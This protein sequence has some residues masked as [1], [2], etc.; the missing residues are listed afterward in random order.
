MV[1]AGLQDI[2]ETYQVA[3]D[4]DTGIGDAISDTCLGSQVHHNLWMILLE[5]FT[6]K[7][8]VCYASFNKLECRILKQFSKT[9][10]LQANIV[11]VVHVVNADNDV[12]C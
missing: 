8:L 12:F 1:T 9:L 5:D 7:L 2:I 6:D 11:V 10:L 4:I 3:L